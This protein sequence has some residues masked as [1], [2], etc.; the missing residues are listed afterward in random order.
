MNLL[1]G[2]LYPCTTYLH[3]PPHVSPSLVP[4]GC[5]RDLIR[6]L[7]PTLVDILRQGIGTCVSL[8]LQQ[9]NVICNVTSDLQNYIADATAAVYCIFIGRGRTEIIPCRSGSSSSLFRNT[10][11]PLIT[12]TLINEHLQ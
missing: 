4:T 9:E 7:Y 1:T 6:F 2:H 5:T 10:V 11:E 12:D 3:S 8:S